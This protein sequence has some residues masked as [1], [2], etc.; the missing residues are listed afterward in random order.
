MVD[1]VSLWDNQTNLVV[2]QSTEAVPLPVVWQPARRLIAPPEVRNFIIGKILERV[3]CTLF[4]LFDG[5]YLFLFYCCLGY[6]A[7]VQVTR[8][9]DSR[10]RNRERD[11]P[12][13]PP[14]D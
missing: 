1:L 9:I 13:N 8:R 11:D 5:I 3:R 12:G 10:K 7:T 14:T 2:S 4:P 6:L